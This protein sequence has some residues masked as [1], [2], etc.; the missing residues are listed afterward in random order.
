MKI[1]WMT[2]ALCVALLAAGCVLIALGK[3][4]IGIPLISG[5]LGIALP[6][7]VVSLK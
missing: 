1:N 3:T 7:A 6:T 4:D 5:A 2:V